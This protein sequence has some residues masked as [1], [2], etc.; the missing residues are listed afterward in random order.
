MVVGTSK[1]W[2]ATKNIVGQAWIETDLKWNI[3]L[4]QIVIF[5]HHIPQ[6]QCWS[7]KVRK[8]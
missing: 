2:V 4:I 3:L 7:I 5:R 8:I 1:K 6:P